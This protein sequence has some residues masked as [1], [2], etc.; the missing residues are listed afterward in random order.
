MVI[1]KLLKVNSTDP[2][3]E[4]LRQRLAALQQKMT[5]QAAPEQPPPRTGPTQPPTG[6]SQQGS[7]AG[8]PAGANAQ[9]A[10]GTQ[11]PSGTFDTRSAPVSAVEA[12]LHGMGFVDQK[13][14]IQTR[15][16][17]FRLKEERTLALVMTQIQEVIALQ[18][19]TAKKVRDL[20]AKNLQLE[21]GLE[22]FKDKHEELLQKMNGI[23]SRLEKFMGLYE[24]VTAQYNPFTAGSGLGARPGQA[25]PVPTAGA[26]PGPARPTSPSSFSDALKEQLAAQRAGAGPARSAGS[27]APAQ[28]APREFAVEDSLTKERATVVVRP[29]DAATADARFR[30]VE[31]LLADLHR[32]HA[33]EKEG[34]RTD[35]GTPPPGTA[36]PPRTATAPTG[37]GGEMPPAVVDAL[38]GLLSGFEERLTRQLDASLQTKLHDRFTRLE[39]NLQTEIRDALRDEIESVQRDEEALQAELAQLQGLV[40]AREGSPNRDALEREL[41]TLQRQLGAVRDDI[42][43]L[44]PELF[45]RVADG[46]ILKDLTS[47]RDALGTMRPETFAHHVDAAAGR[48]DFAAWVEHALGSPALGL[49]LREQRTPQDMVA[50]I[51]AH[52]GMDA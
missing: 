19:D 5:G 23:D 37:T 38:H 36:A 7:P 28:G 34:A 21:K 47:L 43:A 30:R 46:R 45:F 24:I 48:N 31:E 20:E 27:E 33:E 2:K 12:R 25:T 44:S 8:V 10:S 13:Q 32:K 35:G 50:A 29:E 4:E 49:L 41:G 6:T 26:A 16:P 42:K 40:Q 52:D 1:D 15:E 11:T 51:V 17:E 9:Q 14:V 39:T 22:T 18:N 3:A